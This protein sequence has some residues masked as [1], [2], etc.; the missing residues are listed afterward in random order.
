ME[1]IHRKYRPLSYGP[2]TSLPSK[3]TILLRPWHYL[4]VSRYFGYRTGSRGRILFTEVEEFCLPFRYELDI[5]YFCEQIQ[6]LYDAMN[7]KVVRILIC[8]L[9]FIMYILFY[10]LI[11]LLDAIV[12]NC[13]NMF[14]TPARQVK[15]RPQPYIGELPWRFQHNG[16]TMIFKNSI[17]FHGRMKYGRSGTLFRLRLITLL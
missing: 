1:P 4:E 17:R 2:V 10:F 8:I 15:C 12:V 7:Y 9:D 16:F 6:Y 5:R 14:F 13:L 11:I 3:S